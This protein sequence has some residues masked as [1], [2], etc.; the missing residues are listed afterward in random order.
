MSDQVAATSAQSD[1][2]S[3]V[4]KKFVNAATQHGNETNADEENIVMLAI[5]RSPIRECDEPVQHEEFEYNDM[6]TEAAGD[7]SNVSA[8]TFF[9]SRDIFQYHIGVNNVSNFQLFIS[10]PRKPLKISF[11]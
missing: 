7:D 4:K 6:L 1:I 10:R 11:N 2:T 9:L 3:E 5:T 8:K